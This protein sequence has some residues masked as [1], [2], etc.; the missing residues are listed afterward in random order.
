M[1]LTLGR[2]K[3]SKGQKDKKRQKNDQFF[4][5]RFFFP[6]KKEKKEIFLATMIYNWA[7]H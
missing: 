4:R 1:K 7:L 5:S 3:L 2:A 6:W